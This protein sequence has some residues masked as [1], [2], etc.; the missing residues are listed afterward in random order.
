MSKTKHPSLFIRNHPT[1]PQLCPEL[2]KEIG[3]NE[4]ILLL[5]WEYWMR[6]ESEERDGFL[7][8]RKTEREIHGFFPFWGTGSIHR[9]LQSLVKKGFLVAGSYDTAPGRGAQWFRIEWQTIQTLK[10]LR[11]DC[12]NLEQRLLQKDGNPLQSGAI[13]FNINKDKDIYTPSGYKQP[14]KQPQPKTSHPPEEFEI[15]DWM[16]LYLEERCVS[17]TKKEITDLTDSWRLA[18][19]ADSEK[20]R[21]LEQWR[22]DW[23]RYV[24][25][26]WNRRAQNGNGHKQGEADRN[27]HSALVAPEKPIGYFDEMYK[28]FKTE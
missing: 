21:T 5:Q 17:F 28:D 15:T 4:S 20:K 22:N 6:S 24:C 10:S 23:L 16:Y 19:L 18:R 8:L 13:V 7:W 2:A 3:L 25:T 11:V 26:T 12:S 9:I 27:Y 14:L 1:A